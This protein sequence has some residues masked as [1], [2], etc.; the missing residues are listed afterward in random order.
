[1]RKTIEGMIIIGYSWYKFDSDCSR[2]MTINTGTHQ[3]TVL[4]P[5]LFFIYIVF[6]TSASSNVTVLKYSDDTVIIGNIQSD[7]D[8]MLNQEVCRICTLCNKSNL[9]LNPTYTHGMVL[10]ISRDP[11]VFLQVYIDV[12]LK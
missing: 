8:C 10:T 2:R 3:G 9:L 4:S 12:I 6:I 7:K 1:M 5:L 11:P